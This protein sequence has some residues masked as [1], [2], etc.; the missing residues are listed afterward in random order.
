MYINLNPIAATLLAATMLHE[1][2]SGSFVIGF[3]AVVV[4]VMIVNWTRQSSRA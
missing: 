1:Q 2:L 3:V 4:G